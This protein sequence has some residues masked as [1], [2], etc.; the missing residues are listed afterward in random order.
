MTELARHG[1]TLSRDELHAGFGGDM[2]L[3]APGLGVWLDEQA[4]AQGK[5]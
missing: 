1:T 2:D 3:N 5:G 4:K